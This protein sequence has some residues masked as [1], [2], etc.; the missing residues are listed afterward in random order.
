M[1]GDSVAVTITSTSYTISQ[2]EVFDNHDGTYRVEY[3]V[4]D[5]SQTYLISVV[6]NNDIVNTQTSTVS[7]VTNIPDSLTSILVATTP[8]TIAVDHNFR[9]QMFDS[10]GNPI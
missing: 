3:K 2:I 4:I 6:V 1:G 8:L 5:S 7:V 9:F 10:Y